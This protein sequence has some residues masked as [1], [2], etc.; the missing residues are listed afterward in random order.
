MKIL[1][2]PAKSINFD[3]DVDFNIENLRYDKIVIVDFYNV[4]S[5]SFIKG[6]CKEVMHAGRKI[7]KSK[8][9]ALHKSL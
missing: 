1:L 2:S 7:T 4:L 8:S 3:V 5:I 6:S 9:Y